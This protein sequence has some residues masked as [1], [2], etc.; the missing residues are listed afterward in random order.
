MWRE[1]YPRHDRCTPP[2]VQRLIDRLATERFGS[3]YE[4]ATGIVRFT[5]PQSLGCELEGIPA[6]RLSN[7]HVRFF[8]RANPGHTRGDELVCLTEITDGNLT[9]AGRR[10]VRRGADC[11]TGRPDSERDPEENTE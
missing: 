8:A 2:S 6:S 11:R 1:F 10:M 9:P 4:P 3:L 5:A 7:P